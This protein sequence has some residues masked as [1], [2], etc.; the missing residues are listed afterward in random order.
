MCY[1]R[2]IV[3]LHDMFVD[4]YIV[5]YQLLKELT[6]VD[7]DRYFWLIGLDDR[8]NQVLH[9]LTCDGIA[10]APSDKWM[11]MP[12]MDFLIEQIYNHVVVLLFIKNKQSKTLFPLR[13]AP[14]HRNRMY[15]AHVN[16]NH[17]MMVYLNNN[18][19]ITH[20]SVL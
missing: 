18:Y 20:T 11:M 10:P 12:Y 4:D 17:F 15:L 5:C 2:V 16:V 3:C 13:G 7:N 8:C 19:P 1:L 9:A 14:S 6:N